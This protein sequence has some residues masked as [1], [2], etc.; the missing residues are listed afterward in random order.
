MWKQRVGKTKADLCNVWLEGS[1]G[2]VVAHSPHWVWCVSLG[3]PWFQHLFTFKDI[4]E[5]GRI[6]YSHLCFA[7]I[8]F[9]TKMDSW[10][11]EN[12]RSNYLSSF[13]S[14]A[15]QEEFSNFFLIESST[16]SIFPPFH[17]EVLKMP[18]PQAFSPRA[19]G[20]P[21]R[22]WCWLMPCLQ[23]C[24]MHRP[25]PEP[26]WSAD[27]P[28]GLP[29]CSWFLGRQQGSTSLTSDFS[30][31]WEPGVKEFA[32][33]LDWATAVTWW[34]GGETR[35]GGTFGDISHLPPTC[36]RVLGPLVPGWIWLEHWQWPK[37][38]CPGWW[39]R[40]TLGGDGVA[41]DILRQPGEVTAWG[42]GRELPEE[43]VSGPWSESWHRL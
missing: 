36:V 39:N 26:A 43:A 31:C 42:L 19:R 20:S 11:K 9:L 7:C 35:G 27:S 23:G 32:F 38:C 13:H 34:L 4:A 10:Y 30:R 40:T 2:W 33:R 21:V 3:I 37:S 18:Q 25:G 24:G 29:R 28:A 12:E 1:W 14:K 5:S 41:R 17:K 8:H 16:V 15:K 6:F 22:C